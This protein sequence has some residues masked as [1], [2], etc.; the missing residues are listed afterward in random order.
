MLTHEVKEWMDTGVKFAREGKYQSAMQYY[1]QALTMYPSYA[2]A[3]AWKAAAYA[4]LNKFKDALECSDRRSPPIRVTNGDT[5]ARPGLWNRWGRNW[6]PSLSI[7][8][9]WRSIR[10]SGWLRRGSST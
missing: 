2:E 1:D 10:I 3:W 4:Q 7:R 5:S 6:P 9:R 8:G